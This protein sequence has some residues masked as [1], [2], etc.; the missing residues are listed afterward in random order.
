MLTEAQRQESKRSGVRR[1]YGENRDA[2]NAVRRQR[3][4]DSKDVQSKAKSRSARRREEERAG[5]IEIGRVMTRA[6]NGT[7]VE[8]FSTGQVAAILERTPQVLRNWERAGL[9]PPS[10]FSDKHRFYTKAQVRKLVSLARIFAENGGS[11]TSPK[12]KAKVR[13]IHKSW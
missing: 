8:V 13:S 12:V 10:I 1:W 2:Y 9:I 5:P 11:W 4:A 6:V 3:Y 7:E